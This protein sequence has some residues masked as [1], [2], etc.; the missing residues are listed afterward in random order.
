VNVLICMLAAKGTSIL[1]N[2]YVIDRGYE[3]IY[4][5]LR[6]AGASIT[7]SEDIKYGVPAFSH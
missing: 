2:T 7:L 1:R 6:S 4:E 5:T 3:N